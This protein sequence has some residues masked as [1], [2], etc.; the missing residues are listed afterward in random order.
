MKRLLL[1]IFIILYPCLL[2][3]ETSNISDM[4]GNTWKKLSY[5]SKNAF[6][7]GVISSAN[8]VAQQNISYAPIVPEQEYD[9]KKAIALFSGFE[10]SKSRKAI[11]YNKKE[12]DLMR[13]HTRR[14]GNDLLRL[15]SIYSITNIQLY[16]GLEKLYDNIKNTNILLNEA[17]YLVRKQ[18]QG[19]SDEEIQAILLWLRTPANQRTFDQLIYTDKMGKAFYAI[20]P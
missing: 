4:N 6:T 11:V 8:Y 14:T 19:A 1:I 12:V 15:Y 3:A 20:F 10:K 2:H 7:L 18:I 5:T 17:V 9:T 16:E 13:E